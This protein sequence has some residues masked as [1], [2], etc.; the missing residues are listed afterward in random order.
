MSS[1]LYFL[2]WAEM[3]PANREYLMSQAIRVECE[4]LATDAIRISVIER[5]RTCLLGEVESSSSTIRRQVPD[6]K[7][8][9]KVERRPDRMAAVRHPEKMRCRPGGM[10]AEVS[11]WNGE[12]ET[13]RGNGMSAGWNGGCEAS[14]ENRMSAGWNGGCETSRENGM[15]AGWNGS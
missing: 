11:G 12:C 15:S 4:S 5:V 6:V 7:Y 14:K 10:A 1:E 8:S 13:S 9:E 2:L 3:D